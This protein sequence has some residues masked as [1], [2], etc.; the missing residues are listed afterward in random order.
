MISRPVRCGVWL[1]SLTMCAAT[2]AP[3]VH[4][5]TPQLTL[6]QDALLTAAREYAIRYMTK[7]PSFICLQTTEQFEAGKKPKHWR[8]G[9]SLISQLIWDQGREQRTLQ[10]VNN[11]PAA[12]H[13]LWRSPLVS[14]GEFG[15]LLDSVLGNTSQA[16]FSWK[17]WDALGTRQVAVF[18]Y[19]VDQQHSSLRLSL[20]AAESLVAFHGLIYTDPASGT[21]WRITNEAEDFPSELRT[22]SISRSVDYDEVTIGA[23]RY[24]LPVHATVLLNT[25]ET[26]LRNELRFEKYRKFEADSHVSFSPAD[27]SSA[28]PSEPI[29]R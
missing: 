23:N 6:T 8:K 1:L 9:D 12:Q 28:L 16:T 15:N 20:G 5:G 10:L 4:S 19:Q 26:N 22:K 13:S 18:E 29:K 2:T 14:E 3:A 7:L 25:G 21:V 24:V 11:R 17:G 27:V